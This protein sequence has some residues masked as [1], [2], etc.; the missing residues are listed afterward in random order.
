MKYPD[1]HVGYFHGDWLSFYLFM[2]FGLLGACLGTKK[3]FMMEFILL[4]TRHTL[5]SGPKYLS[6]SLV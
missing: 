1:Y 5:E 6:M 3:I 4:G 2:I